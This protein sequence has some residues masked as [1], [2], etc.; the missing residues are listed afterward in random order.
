MIT[1]DFSLYCCARKDSIS[2]HLYN[3]CDELDFP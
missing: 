1:S 3:F 2:G